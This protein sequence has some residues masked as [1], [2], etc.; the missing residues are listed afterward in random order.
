MKLNVLHIITKLELG[1]AQQNTLY[2]L[3]KHDRSKYNVF[4]VSGTEGI[5]VKKAQQLK[6]VKVILLPG[7]KHELSPWSDLRCFFTLRKLFKKEKIDLV[8]THSSKAGILGR[9]AARLAKVKIIVHTVHGFSFNEFQPVLKKKLYI[10][11]ERL[12][13]KYT[14]KLIAVTGMDIEKGLK[15]KIGKP[16]KYTVIYSGFDLNEFTTLQNNAETKKGLGIEDGYKVVGMVACFKPQKNPLDFVRMAG[17]VKEKHSKTRFLLVGDGELRPEI[18]K[19]IAE[20]NLQKDIIITGWRE[21]VARFIHV[22]DVFVL[23]SLWEG[24]PRVLPQAM[25]AKKPLVASAVDGSKE[26]VIDGKNGYLAA[27]GDYFALA[28]RVV[29]LLLDEKLCKKMG[30]AGFAL[31][32]AWDQDEMVKKIEAVYDEQAAVKI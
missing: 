23:T 11:L 6:D 25:C 20:K 30:E 19:L 31:S 28:E 16:E 4:L 5:L 32:K 21:D 12:A 3:L 10:F 13:A 8:H 15:A 17:L 9:L 24:L 26:A 27:P 29:Q 2:C 1:G 18:E 14:D 7:L 22:L